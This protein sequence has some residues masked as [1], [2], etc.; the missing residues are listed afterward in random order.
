[1]ERR[2]G[3][4]RLRI[5]IFVKLAFLTAVLIFFAVSIISISIL[6]QQEKQFLGQLTNLGESMVRI[7]A[8]NAPDKLLGEED[9]ALFQLVNDI[10]ENEQVLYAMIVD[11]NNVISAHSDIN[12]VNSQ[13]RPPEGMG[14]LKTGHDLK[15]STFDQK[16]EKFLFFEKGITYQGIQIGKVCLAITQ[17]AIRKT[18]RNATLSILGLTAAILIFGILLSLATSMYFSKPIRLLRSSAKALGMGDFSRRI[19]LRRNDELGDLGTAFNKM[20]EGLAEREIIR[21][22]FGKYVTPEIRD[23]IL[24]GQIPFDGERREATVIFA[25]LRDFTPYVEENTPERVIHGLRSYFNAMQEAIQ[26]HKGLVLQYVGDEIMVVFGVPLRYEDHAEKAILASLQMR[27]HLEALNA[28][29]ESRGLNPFR[30][31]VG[32]HTGEVLAGNTGSDRQLSY[33]LIG[34]TVNLASRIQDLTKEIQFDILASE[35]T[36][37]RLKG[38]FRLKKEAS[39]MVKGYSR[40]IVVYRVLD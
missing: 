36:V 4:G 26:L 27:R 35:E 14:L 19:R 11:Q 30:H 37:S 5:P 13:Y 1:L 6:S 25:D 7:A 10:A 15:V 17:R 16:G 18:M 32:I 20:A 28:E 3:Q 33:T 34:D 23:E 24:N 9:L 22:A 29:R 39:R 40:P 2:S 8:N 12:Q 31:G 21:E 38:E